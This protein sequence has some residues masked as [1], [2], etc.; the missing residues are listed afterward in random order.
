[1]KPLETGIKPQKLEDVI[2]LPENSKHIEI[3]LK[4]P[5]CAFNP[6]GQVE[7]KPEDLRLRSFLLA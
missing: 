3:M 4:F 7:I 2:N 6:N 1:M 5:N